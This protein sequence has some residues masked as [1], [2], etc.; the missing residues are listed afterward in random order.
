MESIIKVNKTRMTKKQVLLLGALS[1]LAIVAL[2][3]VDDKYDSVCRNYNNS[4]GYTIKYCE[5]II[6]LLLPFTI[7]IPFSLITYKM[8]DEIF[9][10][11]MRFTYWW[12][13]IS[14]FLILITPESH[15]GGFGPSLSFG[16]IDA[17]AIFA[18]LYFI[19]SS[20]TILER[21]N[22]K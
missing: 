21:A 16:K 12:V 10:T 20:V 3:L 4:S 5:T 13:P 22:R 19:F 9:H 14:V 11:W 7:T 8:R 18:T 15:G 1:A 6:S 2:A 17:A